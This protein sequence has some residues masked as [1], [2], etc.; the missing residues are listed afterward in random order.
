LS[1]LGV[2]DDDTVKKAVEVLGVDSV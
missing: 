1:P 2:I